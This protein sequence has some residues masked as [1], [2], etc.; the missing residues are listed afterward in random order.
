MRRLFFAPAALFAIAAC[1]AETRDF[2]G[3]SGGSTSSTSNSTSTSAS[4]ASTGGGGTGGSGGTGTSTGGSGGTGTVA[5]SCMLAGGAFDILNANDFGTDEIDDKALLVPGA[6]GGKG[7]VHVVV[8]DR[9]TQKLWIRTVL[10]EPNPLGAI[11]HVGSASTGGYEIGTG[12]T[13]PMGLHLAGGSS[14]LGIG[15][16]FLPY[17]G[18]NGLQQNPTFNA[19][20]TPPDCKAPNYIGRLRMVEVNGSLVYLAGCRL[21]AS[22]GMID[23][24]LWVGSSMVA[25]VHVADGNQKDPLMNPDLVTFVNGKVLA[26]YSN[27]FG[28]VGVAYGLDTELASPVPFNLDPSMVTFVFGQVPLPSNDGVTLL[29]ATAESSLQSGSLWSGALG[30]AALHNLGTTPPPGMNK[31][32]SGPVDMLGGFGRPTHDKDTIIS[33]GISFLMNGAYFHWL[34]RDGKPL[35]LEYPIVTSDGTFSVITALAAPL[36]NFNKLVVWIERDGASPPHYTVKGRKVFCTM[37]G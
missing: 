17:N 20:E 37:G 10:D 31:L 18:Q 5:A 19:I 26:F 11:V 13:D 35:V 27:D 9:T 21:A 3:G 30:P 6:A 1:T 23:A 16:T 12:W 22:P 4:T 25:P 7:Q 24:S 29:A 14:N 32:I 28:P 15:D 2:T 33:A 36:N 8:R 34:T